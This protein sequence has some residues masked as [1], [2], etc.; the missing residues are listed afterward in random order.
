MKSGFS[1]RLEI[2]LLGG[3]SLAGWEAA[4]LSFGGGL[5]AGGLVKKEADMAGGDAEEVTRPNVMESE[6]GDKSIR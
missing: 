2:R 1:E 3:R 4:A 6:L 5:V